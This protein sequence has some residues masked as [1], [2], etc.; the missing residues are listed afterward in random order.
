MYVE[1]NPKTK[2]A[3][4]EMVASGTAYAY[5]PGGIFPSQTDGWASVEGPHYPKPHGWHARVRLVAGKVV[6]VAR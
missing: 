6:E 5:Q 2:K 4:K 3:L 1:G